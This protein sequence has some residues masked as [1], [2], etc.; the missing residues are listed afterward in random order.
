MREKS[1]HAHVAECAGNHAVEV[2]TSQ[3]GG[4][5]HGRHP[6]RD[7]RSRGAHYKYRHRLRPIAV[8][9][10]LPR[11]IPDFREASF[12]SWP[13]REAARHGFRR[14]RSVDP[15]NAVITDICSWRRVMHA[16]KVEYSMDIFILKPINL[17]NGNHRVFLD[18]NNRGEMRLGR[19]NESARQSALDQRSDTPRMPAPVSS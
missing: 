15:R 12:G 17:G 14:A 19:L 4:V 3:S 6:C 13:V 18:I 7:A 2:M 11:T 16:G 8:A 9:H 5:G 10:V 1:G